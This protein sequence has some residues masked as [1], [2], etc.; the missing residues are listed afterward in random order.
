M[1]K[2]SKIK[3]ASSAAES[4]KISLYNPAD[5]TYASS[6]PDTGKRFFIKLVEAFTAKYRLL[7]HM[8]RWENDPNKHPHFWTSV[9]DE[10]GIKVKTSAAM[11]ENIPRTG[12]VVIVCNHPHGLVDG[13]VLAWLLSK[14]RDDFKIIT[15]AL[16]NGV[17]VAEHNLISI[18]FPHEEDALAKNLESRKVALDWVNDGHAVGVFPAGTVCTARSFFGPVV[19]SEWGNFTSKMILRSDAVVVPV[20]FAG[21]NSRVF[22]I[23]SNISMTLRQSLLMYE[24]KKAF[25]KAQ[26]PVVGRAIGRDVLDKYKSDP[27]GLMAF[28]RQSALDLDPAGVAGGVK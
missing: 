23:A 8:R 11:M 28:L 16:L 22:Q 17:A 27:A 21:S 15:R 26:C 9:L 12:P 5:L 3:A 10:M 7:W 19:E 1:R 6:Y 24:I 13:L 4:E 20:F 2:Q 14:R 25:N 18:Y